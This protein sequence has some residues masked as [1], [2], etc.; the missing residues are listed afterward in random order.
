MTLNQI[1][2]YI[3]SEY[4]IINSTPCKLCGGNFITDSIELHIIDSLPIDVCECVCENCGNK[5][6]F[7]FSSPLMISNEESLNEFK[8][9]MN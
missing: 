1:M 9:I 6:T 5:K 2:K 4:E 3:E 8:S 7:R